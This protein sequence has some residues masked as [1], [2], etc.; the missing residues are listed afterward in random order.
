[1]LKTVFISAGTQLVSSGSDGLIKVWSIKTN[2]CEATYDEH[3]DKV[4]FYS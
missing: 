3:E 4:T 2:E 1:M